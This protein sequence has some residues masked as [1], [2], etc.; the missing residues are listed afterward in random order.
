MATVKAYMNFC[1]KTH[2]VTVTQR[3]DGDFDVRIE[4][5]CEFVTDY[6]A[7]LTKVTMEDLTDNRTSSITD[8]EKLQ[9]IMGPCLA[10]NAVFNAGWLEAGMFAKSLARKAKQNVISFENLDSK[11]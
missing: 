11:M 10:P 1:Q 3:E 2:T 9:H 4:S 5:D 8:P 6:A 7:L